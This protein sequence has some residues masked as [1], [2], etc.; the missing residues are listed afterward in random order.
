M[1]LRLLHKFLTP[2]LLFLDTFLFCAALLGIAL[3]MEHVMLL[4]PCPL[5]IMQR[6]FFLAAGAVALAAF[7]HNPAARGRAVY[8]WTTAAFSLIGA[9]F[10]L[11]QIYLQ[12]LPQD[13]VPA[14]GPSLEYM[15]QEFP[16]R[17]VLAVM[18][19]GDGNCA[20]VL[21]QDPL[22]G[23]GIPEWSLVGFIMIIVVAVYQALR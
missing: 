21:W 9:G 16:L 15:M 1:Q 22:I 3:Y 18:F 19:S 7:L 17:D 12:S 14:C 10:A 4:E 20:E 11:R 23:L 13:Q 6:A 2:R 5:C 8:G